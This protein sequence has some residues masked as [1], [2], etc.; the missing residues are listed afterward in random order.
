M[1]IPDV[2]LISPKVFEDER[3]FFI[4]TYK[5]D[6]FA[7]FGLSERFIQDN[8][9][10]SAKKGTLRGLHY[11]VEPKAQSKVIRVVRGSILDVAVDVRPGSGT[12]GKW[13]AATLSSENREMMYVPKG[14][15]HG[16]CTLEDDT[17]IIYKC[18]ETYSPEHERGI[19]WND[20]D[21]GIKWPVADPV[22][23]GR[24]KEWPLFSGLA[25]EDENVK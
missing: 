1:E 6:D 23:S 11:Q 10:R 2:V 3:G 14:F 4:E 25:L 13:V 24:D 12:Y 18:S 16:F 19:I 22:L 21:I 8:Y 15:A 7:G 20:P 9:S 5:Y 17:E